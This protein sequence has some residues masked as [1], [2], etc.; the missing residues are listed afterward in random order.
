MGSRHRPGSRKQRSQN[1]VATGEVPPYSVV[2]SGSRP[3]PHEGLPGTYCAVIMKTV[4]AR[5][6]A[7]TSINELLRD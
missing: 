1:P 5:T 7:K 3:S 6:R 2:M 4:D